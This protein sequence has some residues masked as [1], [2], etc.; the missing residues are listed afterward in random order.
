[1]SPAFKKVITGIYT[2]IE[3]LKLKKIDKK[4]GYQT[5]TQ[6]F[7][8]M[9]AKKDK[10]SLENFG[11]AYGKQAPNEYAKKC[12]R[13]ID[14]EPVPGLFGYINY[15]NNSKQVLDIHLQ[16]K[17]DDAEVI[18]PEKAS[19]R[20][21]FPLIIESKENTMFL[22]RKEGLSEFSHDIPI[23]FTPRRLEREELLKLIKKE[24]ETNS[25]FAKA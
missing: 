2:P 23:E 17:L 15:K 7:C 10:D 9:S 14:D 12:S 22:L 4:L 8:D 24:K 20:K 11:D 16:I 5:L 18:W 3:R 25:G 13:D 19:K 6:L 21:K 1:M